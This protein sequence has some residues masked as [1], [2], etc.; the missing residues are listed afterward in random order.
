MSG[1]ITLRLTHFHASWQQWIFAPVSSPFTVSSYVPTDTYRWEKCFQFQWPHLGVLVGG[2]RFL[3]LWSCKFTCTC[4][5]RRES[6]GN[7]WIISLYLYVPLN[8]GVHHLHLP[9]SGFLW[10]TTAIHLKPSDDLGCPS[11][12]CSVSCLCY[13]FC[14]KIVFSW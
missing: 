13:C 1:S 12:C 2:S 4:F 3:K 9:A 11:L 8:F 14:N 7:N 5:L 10:V 6:R